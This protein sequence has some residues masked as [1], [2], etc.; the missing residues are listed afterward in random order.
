MKALPSR[1]MLMLIRREI[2]SR[3]RKRRRNRPK[4]M[5]RRQ[6]TISRTGRPR[7]EIDADTFRKLCRGMHTLD[8]IADFFDCSED[9]VN[10]WCQKT[11]KATFADIYKKFSAGGK[12][13]LRRWQFEAAS[14]G[15]VAMLIFLG[16]QYLGQK[17][18]PDEGENAEVLAKL[19]ELLKAQEEAAK[20]G[21]DV[22]P[23]AE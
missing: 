16:K 13:S 4:H 14:K 1:F 19:D 8:E 10:R 6:I 11:Y 5:E 18:N 17:D 7:I 2:R 3:T 12:R 9:T 22:Q 21:A 15:N 20:G 23:E